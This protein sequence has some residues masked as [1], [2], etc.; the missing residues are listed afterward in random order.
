M[1]KET[2]KHLSF[3]IADIIFIIVAIILFFFYYKTTHYIMT[4]CFGLIFFASLWRQIMF[5]AYFSKEQEKENNK[6]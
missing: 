2:L 4:V 5:F 6:K 3:T 1:N